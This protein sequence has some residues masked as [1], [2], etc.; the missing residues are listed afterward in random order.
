MISLVQ[1]SSHTKIEIEG[2]GK[3]NRKNPCKDEEA[4][5]SPPVVNDREYH[6]EDYGDNHIITTRPSKQCEFCYHLI[7][8]SFIS[9][10][11]QR[12]WIGQS[13]PCGLC[14]SV[15]ARGLVVLW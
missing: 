8:K 9:Q 5:Q 14:G 15:W 4:S 3:K 13:G 11:Y 6:Q 1:W 7:D 2:T 12:A 10:G